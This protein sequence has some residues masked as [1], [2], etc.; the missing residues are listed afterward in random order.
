MLFRTAFPILAT[1]DDKGRRFPGITGQII[2][3]CIRIVCY[4][5]SDVGNQIILFFTRSDSNSI[6]FYLTQST[7]RRNEIKLKCVYPQNWTTFYRV[8]LVIGQNT[9]YKASSSTE[10]NYSFENTIVAVDSKFIWFRFLLFSMDSLK[11]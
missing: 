9:L 2:K 5:R 7:L 4:L 8:N 11:L 6:L 10:Q 1:V 3:G